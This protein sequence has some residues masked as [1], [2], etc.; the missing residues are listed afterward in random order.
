V[1]LEPAAKALQR[2]S[3]GIS[4]IAGVITGAAASQLITSMRRKPWEAMRLPGGVAW[5]RLFVPC[6][7]QL[8]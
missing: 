7:A 4:R 5:W 3:G 1:R 6:E 8:K 2:P